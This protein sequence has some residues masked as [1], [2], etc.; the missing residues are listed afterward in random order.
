MLQ[1]GLRAG[2]FN[3][4]G[5]VINYDDESR[6]AFSWAFHLRSPRHPGLVAVF[7]EH[8][9]YYEFF[10]SENDTVHEGAF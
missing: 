10:V 4:S 6:V 3:P 8:C 9:G 5:V 1:A 2:S 7:T